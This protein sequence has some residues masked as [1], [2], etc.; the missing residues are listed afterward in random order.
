MP[1][2]KVGVIKK[3]VSRRIVMRFLTGKVGSKCRPASPLLHLCNPCCCSQ[4]KESL[5]KQE[6]M[7]TAGS[8]G[9]V[10]DESSNEERRDQD[11]MVDDEQ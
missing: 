4:W 6:M 9:A 2:T 1:S 3:L 10:P 7:S 5:S 8:R 11:K